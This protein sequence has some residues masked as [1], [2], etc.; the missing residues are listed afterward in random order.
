M[1]SHN[2]ISLDMYQIGMCISG[3]K[4]GFTL[5][6]LVYFIYHYHAHTQFT[7]ISTIIEIYFW[8]GYIFLGVKRIFMHILKYH[9]PLCLD[10]Y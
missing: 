7:T 9:K 6:L 2:T 1:K 10:L 8:V 3:K 4:Y 5:Y